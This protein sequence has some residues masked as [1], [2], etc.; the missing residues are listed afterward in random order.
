M[1]RVMEVGLSA[2]VVLVVLC[3]LK[4]IADLNDGRVA[5]VVNQ[6]T[7]GVK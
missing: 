1:S 4:A 3:G 5:V 7:G 6:L 2:I